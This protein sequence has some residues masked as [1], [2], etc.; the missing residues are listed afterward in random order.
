MDEV[1][2][3]INEDNVM[4]GGSCKKRDLKK[5]FQKLR[6]LIGDDLK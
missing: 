6:E 3:R 4:F 2:I 5:Q 1:Y